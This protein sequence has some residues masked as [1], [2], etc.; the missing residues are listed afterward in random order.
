MI[1]ALELRKTFKGKAA[2]DEVSFY[3]DEGESVGLLGPN[4]AG[5]STT[6]SMIS[7]LLKPNAGDVRLNG[8]SVIGKPQLIRQVLGV[9]PQ[10]IALYQELSAYENLKF[11]GG[12]YRLK[13]QQLEM[14]IQELLEIVGLRDRQNEL[15]KTYSG[16]MKRRIN[17][18]AALLHDPKIVI[19][20]EP[21]VGIDPQSRNH[22]L[23][24]VRLLNRERGTTVLYTSHYIEEVEQLCS[25]IY[26][27]DHGRIIASGT[28][29]ELR[30]ILSGEDT[31]L[32]QLDKPSPE[33]VQELR[34]LPPV[35]QADETENGL[36]LIAAKQSD[37][38]SQVVQA[39]ERHHVQ[40]TSIHVQTPSLEDVFLHLTG[41]TLR[42]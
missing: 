26:I 24:T 8:T 3:L 17:I 9:V 34:L 12:L 7:S 27:M 15:I 5:K 35:R 1:E 31:L 32:L 10:E 42:D 37:L 14:K 22:I 18:A 33:L 30:R 4:G 6:I 36:R 39:A 40:I 11:F 19:M 13:G 29:E 25:R 20:D 41:R 23:E 38:L 28:K 2:V 16:G 21:T